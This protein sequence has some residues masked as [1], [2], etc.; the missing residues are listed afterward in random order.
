L[1][2]PLLN[3]AQTKVQNAGPDI[4]EPSWPESCLACR[5][6]IPNYNPTFQLSPI[7][8]M[9][10]WYM[11]RVVIILWGYWVGKLATALDTGLGMS[12]AEYGFKGANPYLRNLSMLALGMFYS[13]DPSLT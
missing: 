8:Y 1:S 3:K 9:I 10:W 12:V 4:A 6:Q 11:V 5:L 13:E 7:S 2:T